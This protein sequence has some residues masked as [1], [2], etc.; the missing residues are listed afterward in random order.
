LQDFFGP[1]RIENTAIAHSGELF[2]R[3]FTRRPALPDLVDHMKDQ[4]RRDHGM[5]AHGM[6]FQDI[7]TGQPVRI[8]MDPQ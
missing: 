3:L 1:V 4:P 6:D 5:A 8:S 7:F 2:G